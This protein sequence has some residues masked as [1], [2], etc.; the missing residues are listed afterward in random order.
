VEVDVRVGALEDAVLV[1]VRLADSQDVA[2]RFQV[3]DV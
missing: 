2:G 3:R 1:P